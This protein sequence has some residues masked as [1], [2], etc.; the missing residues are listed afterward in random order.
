MNQT[1]DRREPVDVTV[2]NDGIEI[3]VRDHGGEGPD[4]LLLHGL[5]GHLDDW[6]PLTPHLLGYRVVALDL[7]GHGRSGDGRWELDAVLGDIEAV[8]A[9]RRLSSPIV[10]GHSLGGMLAA[11]WALTHPDCPAA[12]S[13][14]GHRSAQT[15]PEHYHG[16]DPVA[17]DADL[18]ALTDMFDAQ[19]AGMNQPVPDEMAAMMSPRGLVTRDGKRFARVTAETAEAVRRFDWFADGVPVIARVEVPFLLVLAT[20]DPPGAPARF[21][22]LMDAYRAGL[23]ADLATVRTRRP[24]LSIEEMDSSHGMV[25]QSAEPLAVLIDRFIK[26]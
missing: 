10:V 8:V 4:L 23:R 3:A 19:S 17:R 9:D 5:G 6:S 25:S 26:G 7:R 13:L 14:D 12:V 18:A 20:Q 15:S 21:A 16:M 1:D 11:H 22:P 2:H 24:N